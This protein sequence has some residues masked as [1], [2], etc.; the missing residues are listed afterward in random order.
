MRRFFVAKEGYCLIDADYSQIELRVLAHLSGDKLMQE[1]FLNGD[2]IHAI[3]ASQVFNQ[4]LEWVTSEMRSAAK[5]VNFGIVYGI[6]AFSLAKDINVSV[7]EAKRYIDAYLNKYSGVAYFMERAVADAK[8]NGF[9]ETMFSRKRFI[10]EINASNKIVQAAASRIAMN[11]PIQGTAADIIKIA[12]IRVFDRLKESNLPARL[13]LQ[14]HDE[15]IVEAEEGCENEVATL[16]REEMENCVK[17]S[18]PLV[19]D[20]KTGK[21]WYDTH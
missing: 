21:S 12:M 5:A 2:D 15:L 1:A 19:V 4:P 20:V 7:A 14:V 16:L 6:G 17:L 13:I 9:V 10:P 3:T 11:T 8:K 18:I